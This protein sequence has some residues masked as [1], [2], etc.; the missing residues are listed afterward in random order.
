MKLFRIMW[1]W[2][3]RKA[4]PVRDQAG[5]WPSRSVDKAGPYYY[6]RAQSIYKACPVRDQAG[7]RPSRSV[8]NQ[9]KT[10]LV[11]PVLRPR[12]PPFSLLPSPFLPQRLLAGGEEERR[13]RPEKLWPLH[14]CRWRL[15][16]AAQV[17]WPRRRVRW[18]RWRSWTPALGCWMSEV[19]KSVKR[20]LEKDLLTAK[21]T[22]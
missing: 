22:Y 1:K 3:E 2:L 14:F 21:E 11:P 15:R 19:R 4:C 16:G 20:D 9:V 12:P 13:R 8:T 17:E 6:R 5:P 10:P 7:P 18:S